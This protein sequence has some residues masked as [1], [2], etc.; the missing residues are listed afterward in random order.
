MWVV[1]K[2]DRKRL[3]FLKED[4]NRKLGKDCVFY[5]PKMLIQKFKGNKL[6]K[7]EFNV[8]GNYLFCFHKNFSVSNLY[9]ELNFCRGLK[10]FLDGC[11]QCQR[12]INDFIIKCKSLE[13]KEGYITS[14][15]LNLHENKKY[16]F[17]SGP[18]T[19]K[20]FKIINL[21]KNKIDILMG[22][23]KTTINKEKFLFKP[24]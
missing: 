3:N 17:S 5:D 16:I 11:F 1:L 15:L 4:F 9:N 18:F 20:I 12:E 21:Q 13:N 24:I 8:L 14:N 10:Y 2:F 6:S 19:E 7:I 23:L 22:N